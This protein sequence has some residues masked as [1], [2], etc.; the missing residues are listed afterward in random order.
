MQRDGTLFSYL[1]LTNAGK[2]RNVR[3]DWSYYFDVYTSLK[4]PTK[5][6]RK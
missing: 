6:L 1:Q 2:Y 3:V 5:D 4:T